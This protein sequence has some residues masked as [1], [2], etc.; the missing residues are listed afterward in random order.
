VLLAQPKQLRVDGDLGEWRGAR[1]VRLGDD[2]AG[3]SEV[4]LAHDA[5]GLYVGAH[6]FDDSFVRSAHPGPHEDAVV[7]TIALP[8]AGSFVTSELWLF[9]GRIGQTAASAQLTAAGSKQLRPLGR[10]TQIVEGPAAGSG[11]VLEAFVPWSSLPHGSDW[12]FARGAVRLH[13]VDRAGRPADDIPQDALGKSGARLPWLRLDGGP[14]EAVRGFLDQKNLSS[15]VPLLDWVGDVHGDARAERVLV[16]GTYLVLSGIGTNFSFADLPVSRAADVRAA[17]MR[18][19]T[20]DGKPELVVRLRNQNELAEREVWRVFDLRSD[21]AQTMF[22]IETRKQTKRGSVEASVAVSTGGSG[23]PAQITVRAGNARGL[24]PDDYTESA[25][26]DVVPI[27]VPWGA[28][29][30]RVYAW[31]GHGFALQKERANPAARGA[32]SA[33]STPTSE[34]ADAAR[35]PEPNAVSASGSAPSVAELVQ[36]YRAARGIP[37]NQQPRFAQRVNL[38]GDARPEALSLFGRDC[39]VVGEGFRAGRDF[40]YFTMPAREGSDV[41]RLFTGDVTGDGRHE[42]FA[43][44]RQQIGEVTR[45]I[46]YV[47]S[48]AAENLV[49]LLAVEVSR[50]QGAH[51]ITN[52]VSLVPDGNHVALQIAPGAARGWSVADYPFSSESRDGVAPLLLPWMDKP[53]HYHYDGQRL[54]PRISNN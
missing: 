44:I 27:P 21:T 49:P 34:P 19:L 15:A 46:V 13:D 30:E 17:D 3:R 29:L 4:A 33:A 39:V 16:V 43:R 18:D 51:S 1:F 5:Q 2:D 45:E 20:G 37:A 9:A 12:P 40:F 35:A 50:A 47:Y 23:R 26:Q 6:V 8:A 42:L 32:A 14:I 52:G 24:S 53:T 11:Y 31:D 7:V 25:A 48:F 36:G 28:W 38:A 54:S 41:L 10:S 22:G